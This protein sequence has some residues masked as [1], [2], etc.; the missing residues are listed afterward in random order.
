M[1]G[2]YQKLHITS[3]ITDRFQ[4]VF[5]LDS[6]YSRSRN[7]YLCRRI[8]RY[9]YFQCLQHI[10]F[11]SPLDSHSPV[12][13]QSRR[14]HMIK[15]TTR[16]RLNDHLLESGNHFADTH[17]TPIQPVANCSI[18]IMVEGIHAFQDGAV[19]LDAVPLSNQP[20]T[21]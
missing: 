4:S 14:L 10:L 18:R 20:T 16:M 17:C 11:C 12:R 9:F 7:K 13:S 5:I 6:L 19:G 21:C 3:L 1:S 2:A 15:S 8:D